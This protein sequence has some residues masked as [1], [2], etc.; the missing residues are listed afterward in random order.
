MI[1]KEMNDLKNNRIRKALKV[2]A[3][4]LAMTLTCGAFASCGNTDKKNDSKAAD[5]KDAAAQTDDKGGD[6]VTSGDD[7]HKPR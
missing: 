5:K 1:R 7:G 2:M 4:T 3:L 6:T